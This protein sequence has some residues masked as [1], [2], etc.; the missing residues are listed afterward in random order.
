MLQTT[1]AQSSN[2]VFNNLFQI[3]SS[4]QES[5]SIH[6]IL[7]ETIAAF[8]SIPIV[9]SAHPARK[10]YYSTQILAFVKTARSKA[11]F[12]RIIKAVLSAHQVIYKSFRL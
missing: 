12:S 1:L 5:A 9:A 6:P 7:L 11:A 10:D 4:P 2:I 3:T 8:N